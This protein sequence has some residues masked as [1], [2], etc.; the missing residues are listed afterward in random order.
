[1]IIEDDDFASR[2]LR[3][4]NYYRLS[5]YYY[6]FRQ[7]RVEADTR[8][9]LDDF[10]PGTNFSEVVELYEFDRKLRGLLFDAL[11]RVEITLRTH[12]GHYVGQIA[13]DA[14]L[15]PSNF[16][17][18]KFDHAKWN[19]TA[20]S[21][22]SR[23][24]KRSD[25]ISH[26][27]AERDGHIP[28]WVLVE[29]LDFKDAS[30]LFSAL[31]SE[32]QIDLSARMGF[33][34]DLG[35]LNRVQ[36]TK[37]LETPTLARWFEALTIL[38]N[39]VAH[40]ARVWNVN[41]IPTSTSAFRS[42]E[43]LEIL[44]VG[45]SERVFGLICVIAKLLQTSSPGSTWARKVRDLTIDSFERMPNRRISEMGFT[46]GWEESS[47]WGGNSTSSRP[48]ARTPIRTKS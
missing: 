5:G 6:S 21:R 26:H 28:T 2:W 12:I 4:V 29:V 25:F 19:A 20:H 15:R 40:H 42:I 18:R 38:R 35:R 43:G 46:K 30:E 17:T 11:E 31:S 34:V 24:A 1:M 9:R 33:R 44:Q 16:A 36:R 37:Y 14:H 27:L 13:P 23:A 10:E 47:I 41:Y 45:Q 32:E 3:S 8:T 39:T 48:G 7:M 22:I